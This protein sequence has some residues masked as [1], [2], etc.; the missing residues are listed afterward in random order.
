MANVQEIP[1]QEIVCSSHHVQTCEQHLTRKTNKVN[2]FKIFYIITLHNNVSSTPALQNPVTCLKSS[3]LK[4]HEEE[5][6][7]E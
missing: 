3:L 4:Q 2:L 5:K 6:S 7:K 1:V